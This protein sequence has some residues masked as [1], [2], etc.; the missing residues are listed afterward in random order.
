[1]LHVHAGEQVTMNQPLAVVEPG[2]VGG[3]Q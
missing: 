2:D 3:D 1:V